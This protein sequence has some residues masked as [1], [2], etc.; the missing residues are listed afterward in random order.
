MSQRT[1]KGFE[2]WNIQRQTIGSHR[3]LQASPGVEGRDFVLH[4]L[5]RQATKLQSKPDQLA[6]PLLN[7]K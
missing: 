3:Y 6:P 5:S 1:R 4:Y 2:L 7:A